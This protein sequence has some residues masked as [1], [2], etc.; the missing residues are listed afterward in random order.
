MNRESPH[1]R[2]PPFNKVLNFG[3]HFLVLKSSSRKGS[4]SVPSFGA[5]AFDVVV[6]SS[7]RF[8]VTERRT[9]NCV[10][11]KSHPVLF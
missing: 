5:C 1:P 7:K 6:V 2:Y 3:G 9:T 10:Y 11:A 4:K 8:K